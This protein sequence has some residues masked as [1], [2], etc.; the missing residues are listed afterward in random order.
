MKAVGEK[1]CLALL[2]DIVDD[3]VKMG[4]VFFLFFY[5]FYDS[6]NTVLFNSV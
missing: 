1:P 3:K 4:K 2:A 5:D 6:C